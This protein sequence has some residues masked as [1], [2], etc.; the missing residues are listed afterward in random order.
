MAG[1]LSVYHWPMRPMKVKPKKGG[2]KKN[3]TL[4]NKQKTKRTGKKE[5]FSV[6]IK[7]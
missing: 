6:N 5:T 1:T 2:K 4:K 3:C 7:S